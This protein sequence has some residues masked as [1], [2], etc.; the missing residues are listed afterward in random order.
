MGPFESLISTVTAGLSAAWRSVWTLTFDPGCPPRVGG[1]GGPRPQRGRGHRQRLPHPQPAGPRLQV[2]L[3]GPEG[4]P[5]THWQRCDWTEAVIQGLTREREIKS[6][7]RE[8]NRHNIKTK[9]V[10]IK[11]DR[12]FFYYQYDFYNSGQSALMWT[13][14][15]FW[16]CSKGTLS[17][18]S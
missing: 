9:N 1:G 4:P 5:H 10:F 6:N 2:G 16:N 12:L 14:N 13:P 7:K 15:I 8:K 3:S 17:I 11:T 18:Y